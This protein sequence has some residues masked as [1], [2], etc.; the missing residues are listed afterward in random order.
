[1]QRAP[2]GSRWQHPALMPPPG[3]SIPKACGP[4]QAVPAQG[5]PGHPSCSASGC[6]NPA[7]REL[8]LRRDTAGRDGIV[9]ALLL[10]EGGP[11]PWD[12]CDL[13]LPT[14]PG[15]LPLPLSPGPRPYAWGGTGLT[16]KASVEGSSPLLFATGAGSRDGVGAGAA[17]SFSSIA[18]PG[19]AG[20]VV[21]DIVVV[22]SSLGQGT[23]QRCQQR[24][25]GEAETWAPTTRPSPRPA[26]GMVARGPGEEVPGASPGRHRQRGPAFT[27]R[28]AGGVRTLLL[29]SGEP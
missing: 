20:F 1:M 8:L 13:L 3:E 14:A 10:S 4:Q 7:P 15:M 17:F 16:L 11:S 2:R 28:A 18:W 22:S 19:A 21:S 5:H 9:C 6:P 27:R 23:G 25:R 29:W 24:I 26:P 12:A